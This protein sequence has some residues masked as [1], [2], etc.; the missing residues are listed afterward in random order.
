M[1]LDRYGSFLSYPGARA[2]FKRRVKMAIRSAENVGKAS[3]LSDKRVF[4]TLFRHTEIT[5]NA[6]WM[7]SQLSKKRHGWTPDSDVIANYE[8]LI[9]DDVQNATFS[10]YGLE[11]EKSRE[12]EEC[13]PKVCNVCKKHNSS[14][15][16]LCEQWCGRALTLKDAIE[17]EEKTA[18]EKE[19][20]DDEVK[21]LEQVTAN[22][23]KRM[24]IMEEKL[25]ALT[26]ILKK[27]QG[28]H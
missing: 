16:I 10:H 28:S 8:H 1:W 9:D 4:M 3:T 27:Q 18:V 13:M 5:N 22:Q 24:K 11:V 19:Q 23:G 7:S 17:I 14:T 20:T 26:E 2:V 12:D 6:K 15:S 21:R 25:D